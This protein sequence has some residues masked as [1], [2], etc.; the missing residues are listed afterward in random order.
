MYCEKCKHDLADCNC[1]DLQERLNKLSVN[2]H[3]V[4]RMCNICV[5]H[6]AKCVCKTPVWV[7]SDNGEPLEVA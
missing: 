2:Q 5:L 6:Y 3:L 7:R 1:E 4:Y